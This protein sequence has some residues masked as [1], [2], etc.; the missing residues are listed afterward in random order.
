MRAI[1]RLAIVLGLSLLAGCDN[2]TEPQAI[3]TRHVA[4]VDS[5]LGQGGGRPT[6]PQ[7]PDPY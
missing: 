3:T 2:I 4:A 7:K 1:S 5:A 6:I